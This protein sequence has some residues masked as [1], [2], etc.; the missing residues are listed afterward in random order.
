MSPT[1]V[2]L[3]LCGLVLAGTVAM[4]RD[5]ITAEGYEWRKDD[6]SLTCDNTR[7]CRVV[8]A[9]E[10]RL[11]D[12]PHPG[13]TLL[14]TQ[15]AGREPL[16]PMESKAIGRDGEI[17]QFDLDG[18]WIDQPD[19][20]AQGDPA[21]LLAQAAEAKT[22]FIRIRLPDGSRDVAEVRL[23]G[24][25][26][27]LLKLDEVQ[28]RAGTPL[29]LIA[30]GPG[31]A[32]KVLPALAA[33]VVKAVPFNMTPVEAGRF[34]ADF[35]ERLLQEATEWVRTVK[36]DDDCSKVESPTLEVSGDLWVLS[37]ACTSGA[38]YNQTRYCWLGHSTGAANAPSALAHAGLRGVVWEA[39]PALGDYSEGS[40]ELS[41]K[42]RGIGDCMGSEAW[43]YTQ[44]RRWVK[45]SRF[46]T[47]S[48][49]GF[50]GGAWELPTVVTKVEWPPR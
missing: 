39:I 8:Y 11:F 30:K 33:P 14:F 10:E 3:P 5:Q 1:A 23:Q 42:G 46:A 24:L 13:V 6:W 22:L 12:D 18:M 27:V 15:P 32:D 16:A 35:A 40:F 21:A 36:S 2:A 9:N 25:K 17:E 37:Q 50:V 49:V 44:D 28:H 7:T 4:A 34:P 19:H 43:V 48:C 29:A 26:A 41:Y 20:A 45:T 31:T 47:G 38:G